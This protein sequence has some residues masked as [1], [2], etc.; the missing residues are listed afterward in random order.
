MNRKTKT[1]AT[2]AG[3]AAATLLAVGLVNGAPSSTSAAG[4]VASSAPAG[5]HDIIA[6]SPPCGLDGDA[7][8]HSPKAA[9]NRLKNRYSIPGDANF[10]RSVDFKKM[11]ASVAE[12]LDSD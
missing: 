12:E 5:V 3:A 6:T 10:D 8:P 7:T 1:K 2:L 9:D 11:T 4:A